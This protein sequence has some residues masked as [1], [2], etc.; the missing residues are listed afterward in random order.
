MLTSTSWCFPNRA[1]GFELF[2]RKVLYKYLLLLLLNITSLTVILSPPSTNYLFRSIFSKT[3]QNSRV[4]SLEGY[5]TLMLFDFSFSCFPSSPLSVL[6][7]YYGVMLILIVP[8]PFQLGCA[9][10]TMLFVLTTMF[11]VAA[12]SDI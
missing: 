7:L 3:A 10:D 9:L 2:Q 8:S 12:T 11:I 6:L 5:L 1:W 4:P